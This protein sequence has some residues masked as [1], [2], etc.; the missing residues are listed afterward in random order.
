MPR[1]PRWLPGVRPESLKRKRV[2]LDDVM[3]LA[4]GRKQPAQR[5]LRRAQSAPRLLL[6]ATRWTHPNVGMFVW[7][8]LP[9]GMRSNERFVDALVEKVAF[10]PR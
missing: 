3:K 5:P 8:E 7:A 4:D 2:Q 1:W 10:V 9:K 6:W